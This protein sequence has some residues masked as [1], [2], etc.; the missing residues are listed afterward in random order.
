MILAANNF[1]LFDYLI[2]NVL[3]LVVAI[4]MLFVIFYFIF[5]KRLFSHLFKATSVFNKMQY[6]LPAL[7]VIPAILTVPILGIGAEQY[8]YA[9]NAPQIFASD[10][11]TVYVLSTMDH[12]G[13]STY[14]VH[15]LHYFDKTTGK[16]YERSLLPRDFNKRNWKLIDNILWID[17]PRYKKVDGINLTDGNKRTID[18]DLLETM[19]EQSKNAG[20]NSF[21]VD[22]AT[23]KI[24]VIRKDGSDII[25]DPFTT[26]KKSE[27][28]FRYEEDKTI[29]NFPPD[30]QFNLTG[31]IQKKL[32]LNGS[33]VLGDKYLDGLLLTNLPAEKL[34]VL[35]GYDDMEH[36]N[37]TMECFNYAFEQQWSLSTAELPAG[38]VNDFYQDA[39]KLYVIIGDT[40][41]VVD[42]VKGEVLWRDGM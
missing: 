1:E 30:F 2:S 11:S 28:I 19:D 40:L 15:R 5:F 35:F 10:N 29:T 22:F 8:G 16:E 7:I 18:V 42:I 14:T 17:N 39:E 12:T 27:I 37:I 20:I 33:T 38:E 41:V 13:R 26:N 23:N 9:D 6:V 34:F 3:L 31:D 36:K 25:L 4:P 24:K 21:E 32:F